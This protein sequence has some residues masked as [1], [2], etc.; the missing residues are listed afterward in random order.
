MQR[1]DADATHLH[2][3]VAERK[4]TV[5]RAV[6]KFQDRRSVPPELAST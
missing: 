3:E 4:L 6:Y 5:I 1:P 2:K